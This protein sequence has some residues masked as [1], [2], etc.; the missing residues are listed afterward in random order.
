MTKIASQ[1][2]SRDSLRELGIKDKKATRSGICFS[3]AANEQ[4]A[5]EAGW[6]ALQARACEFILE[7][8]GKS[9]PE[10]LLFFFKHMDAL[11]NYTQY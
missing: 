1:F 7:I 4:A 6:V 9:D 3:R 10:G 5:C 11:T 8:T 2:K